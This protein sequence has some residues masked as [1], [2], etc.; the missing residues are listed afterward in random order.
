MKKILAILLVLV[1]VIVVVIVYKYNSYKNELSRIQ[2]LNKEYEIFTE[3]EILGTS[4]ITLINKAID[5][6][7]KN[8]IGLDDDNLYIDNGT[9]SIKIEVKFTESDETYPME[10][11][12]KLGSEQFMKNYATMSFKCINKQYHEKTNNIKYMLFEQI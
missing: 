10:R 6:N 7:N 8:N 9:T 4:L 5:S 2:K 1:L 3:G 11:I 12:G